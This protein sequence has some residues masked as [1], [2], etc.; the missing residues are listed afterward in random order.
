M[1]DGEEKKEN[2]NQAIEKKRSLDL[3]H[4]EGA[5]M[6]PAC[7]LRRVALGETTRNKKKKK[8]ERKEEEKKKNMTKERNKKKKKKKNKNKKKKKKKSKT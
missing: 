6:R 4:V 8:T 7:C 1:A 2:E 5:R 3:R